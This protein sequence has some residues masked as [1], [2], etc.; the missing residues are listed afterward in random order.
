MMLDF[1]ISNNDYHAHKALSSSNL[2]DLLISAWSFAYNK[3]FPKQFTQAMQLGT[4]A[5]SLILEPEKIEEEFFVAEKPKRTS[6]AGKEEYNRLLIEANNRIWISPSEFSECEAM[7][8]P[9]LKN[10]LATTLLSGG[11]AE[12]STFWAQDNIHCKARADYIN[13]NHNYIV[14]VKTTASL[15]NE[16]SFLKTIEKYNYDLSASFYC[17]GFKNST[18]KE[19][20]FFFIVI[21]KQAPYNYGIYKLSDNL[22]HKG[23][24]KYLQALENYKQ[25]KLLDNFESPYNDGQLIELVA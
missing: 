2:K 10:K 9:V 23:R 13:F 3:K 12:V 4:L 21:E 8:A 11:N 6:K 16:Q 1:T 25:A 20:D 14:D 22:L 15:A 18:G 17:D 5:H 19:F 24:L 7:I